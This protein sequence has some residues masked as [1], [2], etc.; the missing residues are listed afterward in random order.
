MLRNLAVPP[1][2]V[3][4]S[5]RWGVEKPSPA[6]FV[7][8]VEEARAPA[9]EI[10][11]VGDRLDN[12]VLPAVDAGMTGVFLRR[13]PWGRVHA[14]WPDV[15]RATACIDSLNEL[16]SVLESPGPSSRAQ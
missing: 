15:R 4:S 12:D 2:F 3:G 7:R 16:P 9:R 1:D 11:Y 14:S 10:A 13:G 8:I 6:F 5:E